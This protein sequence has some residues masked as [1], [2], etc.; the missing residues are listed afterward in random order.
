ELANIHQQ[1]T[2]IHQE[3]KISQLEQELA[4][5]KQMPDKYQQTIQDKNQEIIDLKNNLE[6]L[7]TQA[8]ALRK[9]LK[10]V[11]N[12]L[13]NQPEPS[14][15]AC[16]IKDRYP[17]DRWNEDG[18]TYD[19]TTLNGFNSAY[20]IKKDDS[21][22]YLYIRIK[23]QQ[24]EGPGGNCLILEY[25]GPKH[26]LTEDQ[27]YYLGEAFV[28]NADFKLTDFHLHFNPVRRTLSLFQDK[29]HICPPSY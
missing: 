29:H 24:H 23:K 13:Q 14:N 9:E 19:H 11:E 8:E 27:D 10:L 17:F 4:T 18:D 12:R 3:N 20:F 22:L 21:Q 6:T 16:Y 7:Q 25:Q 2:K 1:L 26:F 5:L 28:H 15:L